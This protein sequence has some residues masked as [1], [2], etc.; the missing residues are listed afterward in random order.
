MYLSMAVL[1]DC[2]SPHF[3]W[4]FTT[5]SCPAGMVPEVVVDALAT[6]VLE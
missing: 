4:K 2:L 1:L 5:E 6:T 3:G